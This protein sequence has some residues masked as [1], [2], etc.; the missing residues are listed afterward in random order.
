MTAEVGLKSE[1]WRQAEGVRNEMLQK[2]A[3]DHVE[4]EKNKGIRLEQSNRDLGRP[5]E[6]QKMEIVMGRK[7]KYFGQVRRNGMAKA[8]IEGNVE[9]DRGRGRARRQWKDDLEQ[10]QEKD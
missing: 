2:N 8:L 3:E 5:A 6:A 9:G 1:V 4:G 7:L 10:W